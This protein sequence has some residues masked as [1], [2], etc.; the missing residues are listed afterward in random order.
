MSGNTVAVDGCAEIIAARK[1][2]PRNKKLKDKN[3]NKNTQNEH[4][5]RTFHSAYRIYTGDEKQRSSL[6][7]TLTDHKTP[8]IFSNHD[9]RRAYEV[10]A[11]TTKEHYQSAVL[12]RLV[13][14]DVFGLCNSERYQHC[15]RGLAAFK[16]ILDKMQGEEM[17]AEEKAPVPVLRKVTGERQASAFMMRQVNAEIERLLPNQMQDACVE[18]EFSF[19]YLAGEL[20]SVSNMRAYGGVSGAS[21]RDAVEDRAM[22][23]VP[24][25]TTW[26]SRLKSDAPLALKVVN[27]VVLEG[28]GLRQAAVR[29]RLSDHKLAGRHLLF[30]LNEYCI[31]AGWGDVIGEYK[32]YDPGFVYII[33]ASQDG[34]FKIGYS[35]SPL[36][37]VSE[38]QSSN[39]NKLNLFYL[40]KTGLVASRAVER[41]IHSHFSNCKIRGEWYDVSIQEVIDVLRIIHPTGVDAKLS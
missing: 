9:L 19:R 15:R 37:R 27:A 39:P 32:N 36:K 13:R 5:A 3:P 11:L 10:W 31:H 18:I 28:I 12:D 6:T 21:L 23:L 4:V 29:A 7:H 8:S 17:T 26:S 20:A 41:E 1:A 22:K 2:K 16:A 34:P 24:R 25:Y 30:G 33:G 38:L 40:M 14:G 35:G